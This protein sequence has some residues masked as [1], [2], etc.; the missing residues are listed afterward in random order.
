MPPELTILDNFEQNIIFSTGIF[1]ATCQFLKLGNDNAFAEFWTK[2][3]KF[4][5]RIKSQELSCKG[6]FSQ[7]KILVNA[8][9]MEKNQ[10][11]NLA[12]LD[13][14]MAWHDANLVP[15]ELEDDFLKAVL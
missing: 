13:E 14:E 2:A 4:L 6:C 15:K 10:F 12:I 1:D 5:G 8:F 7:G 3:K 11:L 9:T